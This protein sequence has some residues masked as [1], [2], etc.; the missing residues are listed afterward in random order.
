MDRIFKCSKC[1]RGF[2]TKSNL[3]NHAKICTGNI[4]EIDCESC[5]KLFK[6]K[7]T[8]K[9]HQSKCNFDKKYQCPECSHQF[10]LYTSYLSHKNKFH[11]KIECSICMQEI[12]YKN[13]QRHLKTVHARDAPVSFA[14]R[15]KIENETKPFKCDVCDKKYKYKQSLNKHKRS[16]ENVVTYCDT[17]VHQTRDEAT[18]ALKKKNK[19]VSWNENLEEVK[20][21]AV[22]KVPVNYETLEKVLENQK[23]TDNILLIHHN[24][25]QNLRMRD[26][27]DYIE[28]Q[29][30]KTL[31]EITLKAM[32]S[33]S[34]DLYI[35][36]IY[37]NDLVIQMKTDLQRVTPSILA[38][39]RSVFKSATLPPKRYMRSILGILISYDKHLFL[40]T[41]SLSI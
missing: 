2:K 14:A 1:Q 27:S 32:I 8:L 20:E 12:H 29:T 28:R 35:I 26:L 23:H 33:V 38:N 41:N 40:V 34:P 39:R 24:R 19:T 5:G 17:L 25:G 4:N 30:H 9:Q 10:E 11:R 7:K 3:Q 37:K 22:N 36:D 18:K 13:K 15:M 16:H 21:I 31:E 6:T